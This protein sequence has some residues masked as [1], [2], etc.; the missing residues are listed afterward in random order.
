MS[1]SKVQARVGVETQRDELIHVEVSCLHFRNVLL[2]K[3][4][5]HYYYVNRN[6]QKT[7]ASTDTIQSIHIRLRILVRLL[8]LSHPT[9]T[10]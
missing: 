2:S 9:Q 4:V 7:R 3:P 6:E 10:I 5:S 1:I 8:S